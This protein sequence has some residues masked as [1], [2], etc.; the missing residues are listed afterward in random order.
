MRPHLLT[1]APEWWIGGAV[2]K[3]NGA[4]GQAKSQAG[5]HREPRYRA[6][7]GSQTVTACTIKEL[8][9]KM[10]A[11]PKT[12]AHHICEGFYKGWEIV[13]LEKKVRKAPEVIYTLTRGE[14]V[15]R[16]G[17]SQEVASFLGIRR[18]SVHKAV[19]RYKT[20]GTKTMSGWAITVQE[21]Q[22]DP[23]P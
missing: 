12:M 19:H 7:K 21:L 17:H 18:D 6:T 4:M 22:H 9:E 3:S 15:Q 16:F 23:H 14:E 5:R 20:D 2:A 8:A 11:N 1:Q 10:Q 13:T